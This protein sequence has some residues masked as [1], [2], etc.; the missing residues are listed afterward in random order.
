M[1]SFPA[2]NGKQAIRALQ[3]LGFRVDRIEGS[4]HMMGQGR[5]PVDRASS[6]AWIPAYPQRHTG[7]HHP[8][9]RCDQRTI[10][11]EPMKLTHTVRQPSDP[12]L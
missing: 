2:V 1:A 12:R 7:Q 9:G 3:N 6:R 11:Q 4:H 8:H 5:A 10:L